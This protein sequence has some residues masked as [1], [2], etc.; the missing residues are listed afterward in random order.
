VDDLPD[1]G[2]EVPVSEQLDAAEDGPAEAIDV[3]PEAVPDA[4]PPDVLMSTQIFPGL[5]CGQPGTPCQSIRT[6]GACCPS[7]MTTAECQVM[8]GEEAWCYCPAVTAEGTRFD[9]MYKPPGFNLPA[10]QNWACV[11]L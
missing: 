5:C 6:T 7:S 3:A 1:L 11:H 8:W 4:D 9:C 2:P 10:D